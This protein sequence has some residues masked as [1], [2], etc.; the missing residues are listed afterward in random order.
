MTLSGE[1]FCSTWSDRSGIMER[2]D[3]GDLFMTNKRKTEISVKD[4]WK[5]DIMES[6]I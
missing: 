3:M 5:E 1:G 6:Q 4:L 2:F